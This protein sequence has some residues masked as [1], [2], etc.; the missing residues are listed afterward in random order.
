M[1]KLRFEL[2]INAGLQLL[3]LR[4]S[5]QLGGSPQAHTADKVGKAG[6]TDKT[7]HNMDSKSCKAGQQ[8]QQN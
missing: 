7:G 1:L 3:S 5:P 8:R 4:L 6:N 2:E